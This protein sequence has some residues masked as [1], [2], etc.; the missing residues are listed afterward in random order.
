[1][2]TYLDTLSADP[3]RL[4]RGLTRL[5]EDQQAYVE[6]LERLL[7]EYLTQLDVNVLRFLML[8]QKFG[9]GHSETMDAERKTEDASKPVTELRGVVS[10]QREILALFRSYLDEFERTGAIASLAASGAEAPVGGA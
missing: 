10:R 1:M 3:E 4:R 5:V 9:P 8:R 7:S 6:R 2:A